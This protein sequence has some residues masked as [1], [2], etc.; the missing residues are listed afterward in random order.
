MEDI[1]FSLQS[2]FDGYLTDPWTA[3][4]EDAAEDHPFC[5]PQWLIPAARAFGLDDARLLCGWQQRGDGRRLVFLAPARLVT[6][7][8]G[9]RVLEISFWNAEYAP[10]STPLLAADIAENVIDALFCRAVGDLGISAILLKDQRVGGPVWAA[11]SAAAAKSG[12]QIVEKRR[13]ERAVLIGPQSPDL[14]FDNAFRRKKRKDFA[15]LR[16]RLED[17]GPVS[18]E[19]ITDIN[20]ADVHIAEFLDL[21]Q[22]G[23]KGRRGTALKSNP[24]TLAL[25]RDT[26]RAMMAAGLA[27]IHLMRLAGKPIAGLLVFTAGSEAVTWKIAYDETYAKYSPGVL[28]ML[29]VSR[30]L[31]RDSSIARTDS[32][33]VPDHPMISHL[34][35]DRMA[36]ADGIVALTPFGG[37]CG[38]IVYGLARANRIT[39]AV[40][41]RAVR[42]LR[43]F[44]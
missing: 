34:W 21:E 24:A 29:D 1:E 25:S 11:L 42:R 32:L 18:T 2:P 27:R 23:W 20:R 7:L 33:A 6:W 22:A 38:R 16:R 36:I 17:H 14:Y 30:S 12:R 13:H 40:V 26:L 3:L 8:P 39:R 5:R 4:V 44:R 41:G 15:R 19:T 28:L 9:L 43:H 31:L 37:F 10:V 35:G